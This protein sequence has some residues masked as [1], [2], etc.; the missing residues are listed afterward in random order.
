VSPKL[1]GES[2]FDVIREGWELRASEVD[3]DGN[4]CIALRWS[5]SAN[6]WRSQ[7]VAGKG[8]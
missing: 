3:G 4:D 1:G 7:L 2:C 5:M 6:T 8:A